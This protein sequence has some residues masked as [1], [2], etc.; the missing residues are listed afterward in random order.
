M[1]VSKT[2]ALV[3]GQN[4]GTLKSLFCN[5]PVETS[6]AP[7]L[8]ILYINQAHFNNKYG[9]KIYYYDLFVVGQATPMLNPP[10]DLEKYVPEEDEVK[11]LR[12]KY[13]VLSGQ[14]LELAETPV[15]LTVQGDKR[16]CFF[17]QGYDMDNSKI[18]YTAHKMKIPN[19]FNVIIFDRHKNKYEQGARAFSDTDFSKTFLF[20]PFVMD[21][22]E[23]I[24]DLLPIDIEFSDF[25]EDFD[26]PKLDWERN[27]KSVLKV[28]K[29][30]V[31]F[32]NDNLQKKVDCL[33]A[34]NTSQE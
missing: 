5:F 25:G 28:L 3:Y 24:V 23:D 29:N 30:M 16:V 32:S 31:Y 9:K 6:N 19:N 33:S 27:R 14:F 7:K 12:P 10:E 17:G 2:V 22:S 4:M 1:Q 15:Y 34:N 13:D 11:I 18:L 26:P 20:L 21:R 8:A